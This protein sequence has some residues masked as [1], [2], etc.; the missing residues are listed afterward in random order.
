[1]IPS[2]G[3]V[4]EAERDADDRIECV[5]SPE[6]VQK[7]TALSRSVGATLA[8]A[9]SLAWGLVLR[10]LNR[11]GDVVFTTIAS[12]RDGYSMDVSELTGLFLNPVPLRIHPEKDA[13]VRQELRRL[14]LQVTETKPYDFCPLGDIQSALGGDIRLNGLFLSFENYI[15]PEK[16]EMWLRPALI[17]EEH[18]AGSVDLD[19]VVRSDGGISLLLCF[20]PAAYRATDMN[21]MMALFENYVAHMTED[22]D[23]PVDSLPHLSNADLCAVLA[24]SKGDVFSRRSAS[25]PPGRFAKGQPGSSRSPSR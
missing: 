11:T 22:P 25:S 23:L 15:E 9:F 5:L 16:G 18:E 3:E 4:P 10:T 1:M 6:T 21:R 20:D 14:H 24:L 17:R 2:W 7:L 19:A 12:G 8:D 13:T